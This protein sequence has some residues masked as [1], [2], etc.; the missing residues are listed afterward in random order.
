M[1]CWHVDRD[2]LA[3]QQWINEMR[4]LRL[5]AMG[6]YLNTYFSGLLWWL[7]VTDELNHPYERED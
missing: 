4:R 5:D 3:E 6:A 1:T 7:W 2:I